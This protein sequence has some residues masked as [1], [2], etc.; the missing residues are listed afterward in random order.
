MDPRIV[1]LQN[2]LNLSR[3]RAGSIGFAQSLIQQ[4]ARRGTLSASQWAWVVRLA[5]E[6]FGVD[7]NGAAVVAAI[8]APAARGV[9]TWAAQ[10]RTVRGWL[11]NA[12]NSG[13]RRPAI[14]YPS[15]TLTAPAPTSRWNG[16]ETVFVRV[17]Q[18]Y[19]GRFTDGAFHQS[20][21]APSNITELLTETM[22]DPLAFAVRV[23]QRT[24]RCCFCA[25]ELTDGRSVSVGYGPVC[26][27]HYG[28][29]WGERAVATRAADGPD[30]LAEEAAEAEIA[31]RQAGPRPANVNAAALAAAL[32][33]NGNSAVRA[34]AALRASPNARRF[35]A[36]GHPV[37]PAVRDIPSF[38]EGGPDDEDREFC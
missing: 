38:A 6:A 20:A 9:S 31:E 5:N 34:A 37:L 8:Q 30:V 11:M 21:E 22:A 36:L 33:A 27:G 3:V 26:A 1:A 12:R 25:R 14:R 24:G 13:L 19:A 10:A 18:T 32:A 15:L 29:P 4:H 7:A 28:L 16:T 35:G 23:G 2:A 17:G